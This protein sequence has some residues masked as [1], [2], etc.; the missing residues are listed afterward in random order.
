MVVMIV[1][2]VVNAICCSCGEH[3]I[4]KSQSVIA[5]GKMGTRSRGRQKYL[6]N[7]RFAIHIIM[8][9]AG[10]KS[11]VGDQHKSPN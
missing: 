9:K 7:I 8:W 2:V 5:E 1:A 3:P 10:M 11:R 6:A 4:S